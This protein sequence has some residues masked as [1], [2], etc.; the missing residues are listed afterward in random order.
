MQQLSKE[1]LVGAFDLHVHGYPEIHLDLGMALDDVEQAEYAKSKGMAGYILKSH[2]WPTMD[3]VYHIRQRVEGI[4]IVP[5]IVLNSIV[6]GIS[7]GLLEAAILQGCEA[8]FFPTWTS[9]N[10]LEKGG[11]SRTIAKELP[12]LKSFLNQGLT[13]VDNDGKLT[14]NARATLKVAADANMTIATGHLS[15]LEIVAL[16]HEAEKI[17][18]RKLVV[19]H[20]DSKS[21]VATDSEIMES[22]KSGAFIEWTLHGMM[23]KSQRMHPSKIVEWISKIGPTQCVLTTDVFGRSSLP[24]PDEF[25]LY[26]GLLHE[27]GISTEDIKIMSHTNPLFLVNMT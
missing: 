26:L 3:R 25:Q 24:E 20:P 13:V 16:A 17:G 22:V 6:G 8:A 2:L 9:Q 15:G 7:P 5:S 21:V 12:S 18:Y 23:P 27:F 19:T 14:P 1:L 4:K 10:D 11:F